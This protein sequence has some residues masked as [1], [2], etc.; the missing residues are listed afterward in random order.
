[1]KKWLL[2][3]AA[4]PAC[5]RP[6]PQGDVAPG[7]AA[8]A[9]PERDVRE[10]IAGVAGVDPCRWLEDARSEEVKAW[11]KAQDAYARARVQELP[12]REPFAARL[13]ELLY[14]DTLSAPLHRGQRY[15]YTRRQATRE[16]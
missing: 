16:K 9:T 1:M 8:P 5:A 10:R 12:G 3:I 6:P 11:M 13:R 7:P 2:L 4:L 15:F 14:L